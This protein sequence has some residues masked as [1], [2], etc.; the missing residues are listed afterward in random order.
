MI[1]C[2]LYFSLLFFHKKLS[3]S[4]SYSFFL[5]SHAPVS[6]FSIPLLHPAFLQSARPSSLRVSETMTLS[7]SFS[8]DAHV[9]TD[10]TDWFFSRFHRYSIFASQCH[11]FRFSSTQL[12]PK[13]SVPG[14]RN[15]NRFSIRS[16][17]CRRS[18]VWKMVA[19]RLSSLFFCR[20]R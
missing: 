13:P 10:C 2:L 14:L 1:C 3:P 18:R 16:K 20:N 17:Y 7:F 19:G 4:Y 11:G 15:C 12:I 9:G 5:F 8:G 6:Y